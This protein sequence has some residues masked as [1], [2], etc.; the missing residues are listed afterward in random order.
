MNRKVFLSLAVLALLCLLTAGNG[1]RRASG[2][3]GTVGRRQGQETGKTKRSVASQPEDPEGGA[4]GRRQ[5]Q[6]A[7]KTE[8]GVAPQPDDR[9]EASR[10]ANG[11]LPARSHGRDA[12]ATFPP[13]ID[14]K[15]YLEL[16]ERHVARLRGI[17]PG[18][19]GDPR[20]RAGAIK[21]L[22][23]QETAIKEAAVRGGGNRLAPQVIPTWTE[24]GPRPLP[25]GETQQPGVTA[26]VSG[27]ATAV[28]VDPTNSNKVYLGTA[29]GGVWRSTDGGATWTSIFDTAQSLAIGS[30]ALAPSSPTTLYVGTG[31]HPGGLVNDS[32]FGV[33]VYR[34]DNADTTATLAGPIDPPHSFTSIFSQQI[35]TTCFGGRAINKILVHPTNPAIVFVSTTGSFSGI[36]GQTLGSELPPLGLRGL[37]RSTNATAAPASVT[38]EKL[39][40]STDASYDS[41]GTGNTGIWDLAF[42]P[43]N[44]NVLLATVAGSSPPIGG[45]FRSTNVLAA[46]PTFTQVLTPTLDP[47]GLAMKLAINKVGSV[48]TVYATSNEPSSCPGEDGRVRKSIDGGINWS[49]VPAAD[50]FCGGLCIYSDP[51]AIDPNNANLVYL[52]GSSRGTCADVLQRSSDGGTTFVRD[53]TGLHSDAHYIFIDPGT[54]PA[55]VWF[56]NDGGVW[57]RQ[58][59]APGTAWE[60]K[61]NASL[62]TLQFQS[63]AV[64]P[65]DRNFTIGGTQD[66]GTEAQQTSPG[67]WTSAEGGDGGFAL[68]D[69]S[70]T[71]TANVTMY[72]TFHN[73][74]NVFIGFSRTKLG[75]CLAVKDSWEFRGAGGGIDA[76]PSCDGTAR[77]ATNGLNLADNVNFYAPMA[78]GPGTPNTL[79]FGTDKLY[80]STDRGDTMSVVSQDPLSGGT[81]VSAIGISRT[82]DDV[83]L[84]GLSDGKV[85][86]TV[87]GAATLTDISP[88]LPDDPNGAPFPDLKYISR[89]VIDPNDPNVAYITLSYYTPGGQGVFKTTNLNLAGTGTVTW[90]TAGNGIPSIPINA[91]V[92]DPANSNLLFAG[93]DIG[94]YLSADAGANWSPYGT[95]LPRVA[96]FDMAIQPTSHTLRVA[97]HGRGMWE[98][99]ALGQ[100]TISGHVAN[101]VNGL[102]VPNTTMTLTGDSG[103]SV[104]TGA[105]GNYTLVDIPAGGNYSV[106][107][108]KAPTVN[109]LESFD[110]SFVTRLVAGLDPAPGINLKTAADADGDGILTSFDASLIARKVAGLS[111]TALVGTWKFLPASRTYPSLSAD[112]TAQN[113]DAILVGDT[114]GSWSGPVPSGD[115]GGDSHTTGTTA[116]AAQ[117]LS[118]PSNQLVTVAVSLPNA[119]GALNANV[120]IPITV[121]DLT[122]LGVRAYDLQVTFNPAI[123]QPLTTPYDNAGTLSS[124]MLITP[125]AN[126]A[127]HLIISAFQT[128]DLSGSGTLLNLR[129]KVVG[130]IGQS[131]TLVFADYTDPNPRF[132]PGF[133]FNAGNPQASVTDGS[134][135]VTAGPGTI[136]GNITDSVGNALGG[137]VLTLNGGTQGA[138]QTRKAISDSHGNYRFTAVENGGFYTVTPSLANYG[139]NPT[140][141]SFSLAGDKTDTNFTGTATA[142]PTANPLDTAEFFVR[143]HYLDFLGREPDQGGFEYWSEQINQC[144]GDADCVRSRRVGVSAAF[145]IEQ[146]FQQTGSFIY[147]LY[148][149]ALGRQ[150]TFAEYSADRMQVV[151]GPTLEA[152]KQSFAAA[153]V[154]RAE[155]ATKYAGN[156]TAESFVDALLANVQLSSGVNLSS[157][158]ASLIDRYNTGTNQ[159]ESRAL[160]VR[161]VAENAALRAAHYNAAFVL[162][163][164]F[165]YLQRNPDQQGYDFW[166]NV[167]NTGAANNY[168]GMVCS[169]ITSAEYQRRFSVVVSHSN[170][171]CGP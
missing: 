70:A 111:G 29:Q 120:S 115:G 139:F 138:P 71:D 86:A 153:F 81:P 65:T 78:L 83:R 55:T 73:L 42:E 114:S 171:E 127:G 34:I 26:P 144:Q 116:I 170:A 61:N 122:G 132:H 22:E 85:F 141:R 164:Y 149:A 123:L 137:V 38:F 121:G 113:F 94:V 97:T 28:V 108:S 159:T 11:I 145:F 87:T 54:S 99:T 147:E 143:Q 10:T 18:V 154:A 77:K 142:P 110:A 45:V 103:S 106:T 43:G 82:N 129:F 49:D 84:V 57:K 131:S 12:R 109:G 79:Y 126:N 130:A 4:V 32:F 96:V 95:G 14:R 140:E 104:V 30:L 7:G 118:S 166:L 150:P 112:Q 5:G 105:D 88:T 168:R 53:D 158:R 75:S 33:G 50:G 76:T 62:G 17:A 15:T 136:S 8:T 40:V 69:Q 13:D 58:D 152:Q 163:E 100:F 36:S 101:G 67:N 134:F 91:F 133:Q 47:D 89:A 63:V 41:P 66:N 60:N 31:E 169:F 93:T 151:G 119:S 162:V 167:L 25:N 161:E 155:F 23:R 39:T 16:R 1:V 165:A 24:L 3:G 59:A 19:A 48:V 27:R 98:I 37:Y 160:V 74:S 2:S 102:N 46:N 80:R 68:I 20:L 72:H 107:P 56:A 64:H 51:I 146:E 148:L 44:P 90:S 157:Q 156:T 35:N 135:T 124:G 125:N 52:G 128:T 21:E 6:E 9:E 117:A 92:I